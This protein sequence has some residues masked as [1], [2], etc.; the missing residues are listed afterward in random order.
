MK[1]RGRSIV[2]KECSPRL[3][4]LSE[5]WMDSNLFVF[6]FWQSNGKAEKFFGDFGWLEAG[7]ESTI[8]VSVGLRTTSI[9]AVPKD[10]VPHSS[11]R[12]KGES[13]SIQG[14]RNGLTW[15]R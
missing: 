15:G 5:T 14:G 3:F 10:P 11:R 9:A 7:R 4:Q 2:S 1:G 6:F 12:V 13:T 8:L